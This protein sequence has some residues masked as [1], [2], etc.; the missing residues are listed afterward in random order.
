VDEFFHGTEGTTYGG[1][2]MQSA[3][4]AQLS[5]PEF[6][7]HENGQV[8]EHI[9]LLNGIVNNQPL[10]TARTVAESTLTAIMGR[11]ACYTG[12]LVRW[13]DLTTNPQSP[14]YNLALAPSPADFENGKVVA[15]QDNVWPIPGEA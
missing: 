13:S 4:L 12:Q 9:D 5:V 10:N 14:W 7:T 11:I 2:K 6:K 15:P 8:Q 1:G 3:K